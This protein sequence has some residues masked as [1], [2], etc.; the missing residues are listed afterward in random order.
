MQDFHADCTVNLLISS[1]G[2]PGKIVWVCSLVSRDSV[3]LVLAR[4][5]MGLS[6]RERSEWQALLFGLTQARRLQQE[7]VE[8]CSGFSSLVDLPGR[9][10]D[11]AIQSIKGKVEEAWGSFR[12]RRAGKLASGEER[13]LR[14]WAEAAF[15]RKNKGER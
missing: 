6:S 1:N 8:L 9:H 11:P 5:F 3:R 7:K 4:R 2:K 15:S 14:D 13:V 10:R 12:L